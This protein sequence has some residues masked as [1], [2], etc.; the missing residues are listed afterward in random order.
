M[1]IFTQR[2]RN[3]L[4]H[5]IITDALSYYAPITQSKYLY[6]MDTKKKKEYAAPTTDVVELRT[7]GQLLQMSGGDFP[8]WFDGGDLF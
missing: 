7:E 6:K 2:M 5:C 8:E 4:L 3:S 1:C